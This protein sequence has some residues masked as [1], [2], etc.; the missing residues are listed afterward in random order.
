MLALAPRAISLAVTALRQL[1]GTLQVVQ[2]QEGGNKLG[3]GFHITG[4]SRHR[5]KGQVTKASP[6]AA[7]KTTPFSCWTTHLQ[8]PQGS[9]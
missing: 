4:P 1:H 9:L 8:H 7:T 3:D 6:E 2:I 5:E